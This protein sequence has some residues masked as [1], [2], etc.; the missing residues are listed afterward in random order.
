MLRSIAVASLLLSTAAPAL[1]Q[2]PPGNSAPQPVPFVD[3]IPAPQDTP[4]P[5]TILLN[6]DATNTEQGIFRVKET[7]PVAKAGPMALLFPKWLPGAHSP[8]GEIE[9]LAGLV[10]KANGRVIPWTR[11][12]VDVFAFH[13]DVPQGARNLDVEFQFIS[14]TKPDQGRIVA[15]PNMI[16]LEPN[17]VSLYPA[18]YFTRQIPIQM[19]V[20]FPTGWTAAGAVPAKANGSTYVYDKTNYEILVDSPLLAGRY[21]KTWPLSER[22]NLNVFADDP[23]ELAA[24][25]EQIDAHKRLVEQ[26]EKTFGAHHY[27]HYEFLLSI[28][29]QLGG[30]GLEHHRSSENGV[31]PGYFTEWNASP[32]RRNLLPHEFTHSWDGKFRRGA[33]LWTPDYRTPMRDKSLWVYEGQTQFWGYVLQA[34]SGLV[35]RQDTLDAYAGIAGSYDLAPARQW[36]DLIDT[37]NDPIISARRPKGWTSWQRSEDYYNEGLMVWMEVDAMLRQK[38]GGTKS[39]DD[40][41]KAF[42]GIRNG[43][44]GEVTYTF[45]DVA[46]TLNGI[47]PY[48]WAGFLTKRLTETGQPAPV[49]GFAMNGYKLV[50]TAEP[51]KYFTNAEKSGGVNVTYSI[52]LSVAKDGEATAVIWDSPAFKAGMDVGTVIQAVNGTAYSGDVLKA[53]IVAAQ[54]SKEPIKLLVK[55]GPR[56]REV[57]IDYHGGPRYPRLQKTGTGETGLDKLLMPR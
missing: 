30:I 55:S 35:S 45:D 27:N 8:R 42:F 53:A 13:I 21:G 36:R 16:S 49:D 41:A 46:S 22:V 12:M 25:P 24:T 51:T 14:A 37:T 23:K 48:D 50:Y 10:I 7:I 52:G 56:Y 20:K 28:S 44:W 31:T 47:V 34:R 29:D 15:T 1:A 11:D 57:A 6:V 54:T 43:D 3:T 38:S 2:V 39:I 32:G 5:G 40:F 18:G 17:S 33:E 4:Y 9:K 26:A 19:T